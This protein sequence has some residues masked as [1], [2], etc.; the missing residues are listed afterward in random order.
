MDEGHQALFSAVNLR[1]VE[2]HSRAQMPFPFLRGSKCL[3]VHLAQVLKV[4]FISTDLWGS[5]NVVLKT[6]GHLLLFVFSVTM[7]ESA[8][9]PL[10]ASAM[11]SFPIVHPD[12]PMNHYYLD[13]ARLHAQRNP[14]DSQAQAMYMHWLHS[15]QHIERIRQQQMGAQSV[16]QPVGPTTTAA[17]PT[18]V[19]SNLTGAPHAPTPPLSA[20]H[21]QGPTGAPQSH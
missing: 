17:V 3:P 11:S 1:V 8:F 21:I 14:H 9:A 5:S 16:Y 6:N 10:H 4:L 15:I 12:N 13:Q 20:T 18:V 19:P 2:C 7:A